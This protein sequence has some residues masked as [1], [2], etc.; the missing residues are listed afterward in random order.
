M[1]VDDAVLLQPPADLHRLVIAPP[2]VPLASLSFHASTP[3][4]QAEDSK[5]AAKTAAGRAGTSR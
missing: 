4:V 5:A 1:A 3:Q 2:G